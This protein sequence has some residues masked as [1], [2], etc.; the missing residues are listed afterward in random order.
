VILAGYE[1]Y[2][3][4]LVGLAVFPISTILLSITFAWLRLKTGSVW[5]SCLAHSATNG[6]G[7]GLTAYMFLG[8]GHFLLTSYLGVL[9]WLPLGILGMWIVLTRG[10]TTASNAR[11]AVAQVINT[12]PTR[13]EAL[14]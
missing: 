10:L 4:V 12:S 11:F 2:E 5:A 13:E 14:V 8:S 9:G 7:G 3:N 6:I 1:G